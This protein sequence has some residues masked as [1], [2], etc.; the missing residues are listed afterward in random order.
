MT[1]RGD[2]V[3]QYDLDDSLWEQIECSISDVL[4]GVSVEDQLK[5]LVFESEEQRKYFIDK[6]SEGV[7]HAS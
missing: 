2:G 5:H 6:V 7:M 1:H 3:P 4:L